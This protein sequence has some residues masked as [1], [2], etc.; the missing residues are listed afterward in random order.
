MPSSYW[1]SPLPKWHDTTYSNIFAEICFQPWWRGMR[2]RLWFRNN[3][4]FAI[5]FMDGLMRCYVIS[6]RSD[7][8][9]TK[10]FWKGFTRRLIRYV[11]LAVQLS[12]SPMGATALSQYRFSRDSTSDSY[13]SA[14][15]SWQ[16]V[17]GH[18][19][20]ISIHSTT[21]QKYCERKM[22]R[23]VYQSI[24]GNP[25]CQYYSYMFVGIIFT[26]YSYDALSPLSHY[27]KTICSSLTSFMQR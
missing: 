1:Y 19:V 18:W 10:L 4:S 24:L 12:A 26:I 8:N 16:R 5:P 2:C 14:K 23:F 15:W 25:L 13:K 11:D 7:H 9:E 17:L 3:F 27:F 22:N 21:L 20:L 6:I